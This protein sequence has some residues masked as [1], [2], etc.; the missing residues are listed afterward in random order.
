MCFFGTVGQHE[1]G[2]D[3]QGVLMLGD[4]GIVVPGHL[5]GW[6]RCSFLRVRESSRIPYGRLSVLHRTAIVL[7]P[8]LHS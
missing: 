6:S 5:I 1:T 3:A 2:T 4:R 7:A 8:I